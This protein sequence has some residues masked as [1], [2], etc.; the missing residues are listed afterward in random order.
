MSD[1]DGLPHLLVMATTARGCAGK[2]AKGGKPELT[3]SETAMAL[4]GVPQHHAAAL[5]LH[6]AGEKSYRGGLILPLMEAATRLRYRERWPRKIFKELY[7]ENL[8]WLAVEEWE[9]PSLRKQDGW[10]RTMGRDFE[11]TYTKFKPFVDPLPG[12]VSVPEEYRPEF[13]WG[14][15]RHRFDVPP[16][17]FDSRYGAKLE[18]IRD[19]LMRWKSAAEGAMVKNWKKYRSKS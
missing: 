15:Y 12:E 13:V 17:V 11:M 9:N 5:F 19:I 4:R 18:A 14:W 1:N 3:A 16:L 7:L 8:V 2:T 10:W 6:D